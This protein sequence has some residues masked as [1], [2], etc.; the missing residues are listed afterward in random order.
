VAR[1]KLLSWGETAAGYPHSSKG[2]PELCT[3]PANHA[4]HRDVVNCRYG[5]I[6]KHFLGW[7]L[8]NNQ[9][10]ET[11][12]KTFGALPSGD[13]PPLALLSLSRL[14]YRKKNLGEAVIRILVV[15]PTPSNRN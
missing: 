11:L 12:P 10:S 9:P 4:N 8:E 5:T 15:Y 6:T 3:C 7:I 2:I 1:K 14:A 13:T